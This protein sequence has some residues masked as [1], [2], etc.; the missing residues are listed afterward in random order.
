MDLLL[1]AV[2]LLAGSALAA[3]LL[4]R[5]AR[6][7]TGVGVLGA[8]AGSALGLVPALTALAG[9][10]PE[11]ASL[12]LPWLG[13]IQG[14]FSV[15]LD[16]LSAFFLV[17]VLVVCGLAAVYGGAYWLPYAGR[18]SLG[19]AWFFYNLLTASMVLIVV[20]RN[21]VLF[22]IAW[23]AMAVTSYFLVTFESEKDSVRRAGWIYLIATHLG[24]AFLLALFVLL[25]APGRNTLDFADFETAATRSVALANVLFLLAL[26]G[27]GTKAGLVPLHVWLP[28]AH[29]A[30]PSHVSAVLSAVMIKMGIYG[31]LRTL[32]FLGP[33]QPWWGPGLLGVGLLGGVLGISLALYQRDLKRALAYSS[34]ENIGLIVVGLGL[35]L[36]GWSAGH[37]LVAAL[38]I[39]GA[40]LHIWN[41]A[42]MKGMMF[43]AAGSVLHGSGTKDIEH[44]GGLMKRMPVTGT[45]MVLGSVAIAALPPLNGFVSEW[46]LYL[47]LLRGGL[48]QLDGRGLTSLLCVGVLAIIGGLAAICFVRLAGIVLLG[49]GRTTAPAHA[50][51]ANRQMTAP[52]VILAALCVGVALF[53]GFVVGFM[54]GAINQVIGWYRPD[55]V[56]ADLNA[57][58][59]APA[60]L[61]WMNLGLWVAIG[62]AAGL[63]AL[64]CRRNG[65][66]EGDTWGCGYARPTPRIQYTGR[67][68]AEFLAEHLLPGFLRPRV[69]V[70]APSGLFP[71]PGAFAS[72]CPDPVEE[73]VYEP[74]FKRWA[75]RFARL[76]WLQH[77]KV[78]LYLMYLLVLVVLG[79]TWVYVRGRWGV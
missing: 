62:L 47:G 66:A 70:E 27:F 25:R 42:L 5:N 57:A 65:V 71:K 40:M 68:F 2:G 55:Q 32:S 56:L 74:F 30:A 58:Q 49:S 13:T 54:S 41:H 67:S 46:L 36:W 28:E 1:V 26:V 73:R 63:L 44:L 17:L 48:G 24:T 43:L 16:A 6:L 29:P 76:W 69:R 31:L 14:S 34:I 39:S 4:G 12:V 51:E 3:L 79:L 21:G 78:Y 18:K 45:V 19:A 8:V 33:P 75:E 64:L 15:E 37:P 61:G 72:T 9:G 38:G 10:R 50:H 11:P 35:G 20:A 52:M 60:T 7:A 22:L 23:E 53:P 59:V 77:G